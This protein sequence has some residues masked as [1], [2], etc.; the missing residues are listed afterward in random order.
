MPGPGTNSIRDEISG[1]LIVIQN[2]LLAEHIKVGTLLWYQGYTSISG[3]NCPAIITRVDKGKKRF[4]VR[5][6]DD[7]MEQEEWYEFSISKHSSGSRQTMRLVEAA[8]VKAYLEQRRPRLQQV[9]EEKKSSLQ[10]AEAS[11]EHFDSIL[12]SLKI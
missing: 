9:V 10:R 4:R 1:E 5:S 3:W 8:E 11:L 7:M 12:A 2:P 6:L